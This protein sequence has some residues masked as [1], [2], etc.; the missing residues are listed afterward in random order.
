M[1]P[2][3]DKVE[4][5]LLSIPRK[6]G[7]APAENLLVR[8]HS[9]DGCQRRRRMSI[10]VPLWRDRRRGRAGCPEALHAAAFE[11]EPAEH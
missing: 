8:I 2:V 6:R 7:M 3:I 9:N 4:V 1:A 10:R 11:G 5:V